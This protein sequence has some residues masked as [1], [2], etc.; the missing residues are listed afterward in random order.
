M[1]KRFNTGGIMT[2]KSIKS[3]CGLFTQI[4]HT[5]VCKAGK[6]NCNFKVCAIKEI[7]II[8]NTKN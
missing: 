8:I 3:M 4:G 6:R 7:D 1:W 5:N 2:F